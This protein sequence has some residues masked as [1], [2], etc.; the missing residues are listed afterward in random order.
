MTLSENGI[1]DLVNQTAG[2]VTTLQNIIEHIKSAKSPEDRL[3]FA[4]ELSFCLNGML[5]SIKGWSAW[6]NNIQTLSTLNIEDLK[7]IYNDI[8]EI[9][10][11]FL[12][13]DIDITKKKLDETKT[14]IGNLQK[15]DIGKKEKT[16]V[17]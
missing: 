10:I 3:G 12:K 13:V 15:K 4:A 8:K 9:S 5:L 6:L 16:Y 14:K 11:S 7:H 1:D 17:S 2:Y